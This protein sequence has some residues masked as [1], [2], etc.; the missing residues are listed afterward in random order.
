MGRNKPGG[1]LAT[2]KKGKEKYGNSS[3]CGGRGCLHCAIGER[4]IQ[5]AE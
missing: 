3:S 4:R 1:E 2:E 5:L